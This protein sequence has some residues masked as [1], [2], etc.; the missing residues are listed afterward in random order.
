MSKACL[1]A[2]L[3]LLATCA[4]A[5]A[6]APAPV[7]TLAGNAPLVVAGTHFVP[8]ELVRIAVQPAAIAAIRVRANGAGVFS[9]SLPGLTSS[10]CTGIRISASGT[11]G[12]FAILKLPRPACMPARTP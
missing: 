5:A 6:R 10:R 7:L 2:A 12:T 11:H 4:P 3:L 8:G 1:I 9:A